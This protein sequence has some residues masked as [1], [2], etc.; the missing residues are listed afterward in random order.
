MNGLAPQ[1]FSNLFTIKHDVG[2][3]TLSNDYFFIPRRKSIRNGDET[4]SVLGPRIWNA[5]PDKLK[6]KKSLLSFQ[7]A[8]KKFKIDFCPCRLDKN[9]IPGVGFI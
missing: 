8:I 1:I 9:Y 3:N 7:A 6:S 2:Y 4:I 5:L